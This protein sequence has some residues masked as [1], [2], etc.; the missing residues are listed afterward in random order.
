VLLLG[1]EPVAIDVDELRPVQADAVG[2]VV[3]GR[4]D[5]LGELDVGPD[6]QPVPVQRDGGPAGVLEKAVLDRLVVP[7]FLLVAADDLRVGVHDHGT[8]RAVDDDEIPCP[9]LCRDLLETDDRRDLVGPGHDGRVRGLAAHV[10]GEPLDLLHLHLHRV[11]GREVARDDDGMVADPRDGLV[12]DPGQVAQDP[13]PRV[14]HVADAFAQVLVVDLAEDIAVLVEG[15]AEG[16][17]GIDPL[18]LDVLGR[19]PNEHLVAQNHDV[20]VEDVEG[21]EP[22]LVLELAFDLEELVLGV[23][24]GL[25]EPADLLGDEAAVLELGATKHE[26]QPGT[27]F[28]VFLDPAGH[29]FCL[30]QGQPVS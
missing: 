23:L 8:C 26:H 14:L 10:G 16:P 30:C 25:A 21:L 28:R 24:D 7:L 4:G 2:A 19:L 11:R 27:T 12:V 18:L 15:H 20:H 6:L 1:G 17:L 5:L 13:L 29:P 3:H 22:L 9:G